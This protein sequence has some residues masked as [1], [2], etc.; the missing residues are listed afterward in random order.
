MFRYLILGLLRC[1]GPMHGYALVR[2][3]GERSGIEMRTGSFYRE[4]RRLLVDGLICSAA[5]PNGRDPRRVPYAITTEGCLAFDAWLTASEAG[6]GEPSDDELSARALFVGECEP[7]QAVAALEHLRANIWMASKRSER[8]R[9]AALRAAAQSP[10]LSHTLL[11][12]LLARRAKHLAAD[13]DLIEGIRLLLSERDIAPSPET[14][15]GQA[16]TDAA[17][18]IGRR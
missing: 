18:T 1:A 12:L 16:V 2:A 15:S 3:Y 14:M 17:A 5:N 9:M 7:A 6:G 4:L 11:P 10:S 13:L 8:E